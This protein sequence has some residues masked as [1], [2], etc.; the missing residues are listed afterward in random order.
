MRI[1]DSRYERDSR[2]YAL[3]YRLLRHNARTQTI[4]RWTGLSGYRVRTL[5]QEYPG[6]E[7]GT[8][9]RHR[10]VPPY[11]L[12]TFFRNRTAQRETLTLAGLF[13]QMNL[14]RVQ[15]HKEGQFPT[16]N[17]GELL[18]SAFEAFH[19]LVPGSAFTIDHAALLATALAQAD[20]IA[21]SRC[22]RCQGAM[23]ADLLSVR[24]CRCIYCEN[25]APR[26]IVIVRRNPDLNISKIRGPKNAYERQ[27]ICRS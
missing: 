10:G 19:T 22:S 18:C 16:L 17:R 23:V 2:R 8:N 3:A 5:H 4:V 27:H 21:L 26:R 7:P 11:K 15:P 9:P 13:Q 25:P 24:D 14:I 12:A 6:A 20:E 1:S